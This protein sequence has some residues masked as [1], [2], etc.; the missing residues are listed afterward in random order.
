M[1]FLFFRAEAQ[2]ESEQQNP[3]AAQEPPNILL[4]QGAAQLFIE[5]TGLLGLG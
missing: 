5:R 2:N 1:T 3:S 4:F